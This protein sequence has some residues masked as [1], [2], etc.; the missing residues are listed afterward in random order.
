[1][2]K[3]FKK[4]GFIL[5]AAVSMF[6]VSCGGAE[7][8]TTD[9][10]ATEPTTEPATEPVVEPAVEPATTD[11]A[12]ACEAGACEGGACDGAEKPAAH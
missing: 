2:K 11:T 10:P 4:I 6:V 8:P 5:V 9:A 7:E 12:A 1:M 3:E